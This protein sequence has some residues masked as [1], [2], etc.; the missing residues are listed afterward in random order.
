MGKGTTK[1][2]GNKHPLDKFYTKEKIVKQCL[3]LLNLNEYD[4]IIEPSA[5]SGAFSNQIS[6]VH[7]FDISP[8]NE[9]IERADFLTLSKEIFQDYENILVVGNPPFGTSGKLAYKFIVESMSF[10]DTVAFILPRGFKKDTMKN[11]IPLNFWLAVEQDL[12]DKSFT[13]EGKD[14]SVPCVFQI[15]KKAE[16][17]REKKT[18][19]LTTELF[20]FVKKEEADFRIQRVG[21]KAGK[22]SRELG[23]SETSNYFVKNTSPHSTDF[24][25]AVINELSYPTIDHTTGPKSLSKGEIIYSLE[26]QLKK[27]KG[28]SVGE[29][30]S[31]IP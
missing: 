3:S 17:L 6:G 21:G 30:E 28:D 12:P 4:C 24:L 1:N 26:E 16:E 9:N 7:A 29:A 19:P 2:L 23:V 20:T 8:E 22:A 15:W 18:Y 5:G 14:Y 11:R 31:R 10:A 27:E 13:L 25:I